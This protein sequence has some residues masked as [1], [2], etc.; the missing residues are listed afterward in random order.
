M[1]SRFKITTNHVAFVEAEN[2]H[3]L[4]RFP[5]IESNDLNKTSTVR[6]VATELHQVRASPIRH[7]LIEATG[8]LFEVLAV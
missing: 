1:D 5:R 2:L 7:Y 4:V 3:F 8:D 6:D